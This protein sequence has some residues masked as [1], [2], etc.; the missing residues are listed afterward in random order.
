MTKLPYNI[1][2]DDVQILKA[3]NSA[4]H[5]LGQLNGAINLLPNPYVIFNAITLGE[6][7][8]SSEIENIVTTFDEIFKEMSYSKTNPAS[9]EVLNYRQAMLKGYNLVKENGF[10]SVNH[11]IQIHHIV[12]PEAGD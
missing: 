4:N 5:K 1:D 7:K 6:A 9:K 10:L 2:F 11:I 12:E 3:L 8:E